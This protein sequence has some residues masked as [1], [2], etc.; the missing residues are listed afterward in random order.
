MW[1]YKIKILWILKKVNSICLTIYDEFDHFEIVRMHFF[2]MH[3]R[4]EKKMLSEFTEWIG[5]INDWRFFLG[6]VFVVNAFYVL[7]TVKIL[8]KC[9][10]DCLHHTL[11]PK[12]I[13]Y[14]F[15]FGTS[16]REEETK[17]FQSKIRI[18]ISMLSAFLWYTHKEELIRI[19]CE[20]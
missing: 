17:W 2:Y 6:V 18:L 20:R 19:Q 15:L 12:S 7:F 13:I 3:F 10:N 11:S 5:C 9:I 4:S 1:N 16:W 14:L 8:K